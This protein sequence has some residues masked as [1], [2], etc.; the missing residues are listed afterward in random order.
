MILIL[1]AWKSIVFFP[2]NKAS[3]SYHLQENVMNHNL[4]YTEALP[5]T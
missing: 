2:E 4:W 5:E 1:Y 3:I